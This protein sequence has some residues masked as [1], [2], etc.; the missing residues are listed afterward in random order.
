MKVCL[1]VKKNRVQRKRDKSYPFTTRSSKYHNDQWSSQHF[2]PET[3][4]CKQREQSTFIK[5]GRRKKHRSAGLFFRRL[6][7]KSC[8]FW[9]NF[10]SGLSGLGINKLPFKMTAAAMLE[11]A[12]WAQDQVSFQRAEEKIK[13]TLHIS[14]D[15]DT[16]RKAAGYIGKAVFEEDCRKA[17]EAWAEFCKRPLVS[18]PKRKKGVLYIET[19]GSSVNTRIQD[20]NGST[21]RENKLAIFFSTDHIYKWKN[22]KGEIY[23]K[24]EKKEYVSYLGSVS[25]F[26]KHVLAGAIRNG[27]GRYEKVVLLSDGAGWIANMKDELFGE[28]ALQILD[29]FHLSENVYS[30]GKAKFKMNESQYIPWAD[31][32][33][34]KLRDGK[35]KEVLGE[36]DPEETYKNTVNLYHYINS[37]KEHIDYPQYSAMGLFI[38]SGA[39]ESSNKII[40]QRRFKQAG[41][42]W[43]VSTAQYLM[44]LVSKWESELWE[45][46]VV[47]RTYKILN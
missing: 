11:C 20:E 23:R 4:P 17:D 33:C 15:D 14:I 22:K 7:T 35:W 45:S 44:T 16:I 6:T 8:A 28:D 5:D 40:V 34:K 25:E 46:D 37:N 19:D 30:Y 36:L 18:E 24:I 43:G 13:R 1:F 12:Y 31:E 21:W 38:G 9:Q 27:Y 2:P 47:N 10:G 3:T 41:M 32:K 26:K 39:I 42:R 29:F